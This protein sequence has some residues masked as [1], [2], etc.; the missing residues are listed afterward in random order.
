MGAGRMNRENMSSLFCGF[1]FAIGLGISGMTQPQKVVGFLDL[2]GSWDPSLLFVMA[3]AVAVYSIGY[4]WVKKNPKPFFTSAFLI[5]T[6]RQW[7]SSLMLG[8][9]LFGIGWGIAGFCPGPALTSLAGLSHSVLVF[10][11]TMLAVMLLFE[12]W[13]SRKAIR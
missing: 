1:L 6:N 4:R 11:G 5:P 10:A 3:G 12:K 13:Q 9:A 2:F 8:S 7:D